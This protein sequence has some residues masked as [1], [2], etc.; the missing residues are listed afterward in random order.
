MTTLHEKPEGKNKSQNIERK[1]SNS[2]SEKKYLKKEM[3][4]G[5]MPGIHLLFQLEPVR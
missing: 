5:G 2:R 3:L 4:Q 1:I